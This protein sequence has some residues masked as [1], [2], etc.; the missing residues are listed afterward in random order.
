A[1][2]HNQEVVKAKNVKIGDTAV[3]RKAGDVI[4]AIAGPVLPLRGDDAKDFV[5]PSHCP[6]CGTQ[7]RSLNEGDVGLRCTNAQ[8]CPAQL[9]GRIE[10]AGSRGAFDIESLGE[11]A[12]TWLTNGPGPN[13]AENSGVVKPSG[14]GVLTSDAQLF[15]LATNG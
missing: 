13:P 5:M 10:H 2:L 9:T 4:P 7:L 12:A 1:T 6:A 15:D 14:P 3:L 11:E 8:Y